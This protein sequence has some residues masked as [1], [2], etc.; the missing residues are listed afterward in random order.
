MRVSSRP[1]IQGAAARDRGMVSGVEESTPAS[2]A[3]ALQAPRAAVPEAPAED[4]NERPKRHPVRTA[5]LLVVL[6]G[7]LG[8]GAWGGWTWTQQQYYVGASAGHVAIFQ[9][10]RG[11]VLG[12]PL[13]RVVEES[14][15]ALTD[16]PEATRNTVE[17]GL[18]VTEGGLRGARTRVD[19]LRG[20]MLERRFCAFFLDPAGVLRACVSIDWPRDVRRALPLIRR[21]VAP[22]RAALLDPGV[23]LRTLDPARA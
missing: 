21:E 10:V 4:E 6:L 8:G 14:D 20:S 18:L 19:M 13:Q 5:V 11:S 1:W 23:D 16:L 3:S 15:I 9:G 7:L 2:R 12:L 17:D 22:D